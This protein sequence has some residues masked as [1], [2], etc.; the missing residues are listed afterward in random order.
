M[1]EESRASTTFDDA[2]TE[3]EKVA[4][5]ARRATAA[6]A[7][8]VRK[9]KKASTDGNVADLRKVAGE[10]SLLQ[11]Q[12]GGCLAALFEAVDAAVEWPASENADQSFKARY[13]A[14]LCAAAESR[15]LAISE[16]DG[17]LTTF[18]SIVSV[19]EDRA[20]SIDRKRVPAI[21]PSRVVEKLV[22]NRR[23]AESYSP[24]QFLES[25]HKVYV[26]LSKSE[27][28]AALPTGEGPV[29]P[30]ISVYKLLTARPGASRDYTKVDFARDLFALE[31]RG[32][33]RTKNG[34][35]VFL[36]GSTGTRQTG[37]FSFVGP[38]GQEGKWSGVKFRTDGQ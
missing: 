12:L 31:Y 34:A 37:F 35:E 20:V 23:R 24:G 7:L 19:S 15:D 2:L 4:E 6:V 27:T 25:L 8:R 14:E 16:R 26:Y 28:S 33:T 30:L 22:L 13:S 10:I 1:E 32:V 36:T 3:A 29:V 11:E 17:F 5:A 21:R 38:D 9:V 18:P